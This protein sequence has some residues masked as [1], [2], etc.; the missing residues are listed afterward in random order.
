MTSLGN[1]WVVN[2]TRHLGVDGLT[3][4]L[5]SSAWVWQRSLLLATIFREDVAKC[6]IAIN[7]GLTLIAI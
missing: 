5:C 6:D 4:L 7:P 2:L 3:N 1:L